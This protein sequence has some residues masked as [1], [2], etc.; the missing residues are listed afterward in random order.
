MP[1]VNQWR[2]WVASSLG[3]STRRRLAICSGLV[4]LSVVAGL[5]LGKFMRFDLPDV[6]ALENYEPPLMTRVFSEDGEALAVFAEQRRIM[7]EFHEIPLEYQQALIAT[8]DTDF[9]RHSGIAFKGI[10]RALWS[11][12]RHMRLAQGAS[13]I[14]QQL[15]RNLF[16]TLD[17]TVVRKFQELLLAL[18]IERLYSKQ[19]ILGFYCNQVYMGHG[20]YGLEAAA[21]HY[22]GKPARELDVLES[23]TLAGL[24]QRPTSLSPISHPD[25]ALSR[26]NH[27]LGR[28]AEVGY[29]TR[30]QADTLI[31]EPLS[32][33][34]PPRSTNVA[35]HYVEEVRRWLQ[36]IYGSSS[37]YRSGLEVQTTLDPRL[38]QIA[39]HAV[40]YG[41]RRLDRRQGWRGDLP[42]I[43]EADRTEWTSPDWDLPLE[44]DRVVDGLV[45]S[46]TSDSAT[47]RL[48]DLSGTLL[49]KDADW[50]GAKKLTA[51][52]AV[53]DV[54][55]VRV[56]TIAEGHATLGL[57]QRPLT[58]VSLVALDPRTGAVKALVGGFDFERSEF[59]RAIQAK[60]QTGSA[61]K[62]L[63]FAA[64]F[65]K[66]R[67][68]ADTLLD[69]PT[70]FLD[71]GSSAPY[72]PENYTNKYYNTLTL[73]A[74]M[75]S[76]A[77]IATVK[78]LNSIGYDA[79]IETA[80]SL[81]ISSDLR[82]F[83][84]L[85]LGAFEISLME[86]TAAYGA[87]ANQGVLVEPHLIEEVRNRDG[88]PLHRVEPRVHDAVSPQTA[89]M[90]NR[91]LEGVISDGTGRAASRLGLPLAGKTGTTDNNTDAWFVGYTP[92]MAVG[93]WVG[94][95]EPRS[96]GKRETGA[97]AALPIWKAFIEKAYADGLDE[98]FPR[99]SGIVQVAIDRHSGLRASID[100]GCDEIITEVF[101]DGTEPTG[102]CSRAHH[103]QLKLPYPFQ[104]YPL[105]ENGA[106]RIPAAE[107]AEI[108][109]HETDVFLIPDAE[110]LE[111]H[112]PKGVIRMPIVRTLTVETPRDLPRQLVK[113]YDPETWVGKDGR[114]AHIV[115]LR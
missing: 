66:G 7:I 14:T 58:E 40:E 96:L 9:Y 101:V 74:A 81:G 102:Y 39:N 4:L 26:R 112:T 79:V 115:W 84:S 61:F 71:R 22:F 16:L 49:L 41:L 78:L 82:P 52:L 17:K 89:F 56:L 46:V 36:K 27:V 91:V 31:P 32:P 92:E 67:T 111:A 3:K 65:S 51:I 75:E 90:M 30:A 68:L 70:V 100:A 24:I 43:P 38:Q 18:E 114:P 99:P 109:E 6:R 55:R 37:L 93:V 1:N 86:L 23:A 35:P 104:R 21:Q 88:A 42:R 106:L 59:N 87:F 20:R 25:R 94:F 64:A 33:T 10:A 108:L 28:M 113:R 62:P 76:S 15:A 72:Q 95:D 85:A 11:D 110:E 98:A 44:I 53:G 54:V 57:E 97:Q 19:E 80:R 77:N 60:R 103:D 34:R 69:E 13:T 50:S 107:L 2:E 63:V 47:L 105:T 5:T 48:R 29:L 45:E 12:M 73:R 83:P 8:E